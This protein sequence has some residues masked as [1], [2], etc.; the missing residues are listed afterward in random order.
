MRIKVEPGPADLDWQPLAQGQGVEDFGIFDRRFIWYRACLDESTFG[1]NLL[2]SASLPDQDSFIA[3]LDGKRANVSRHD[4]RLVAGSISP[5]PS[6]DGILTLLYEDGGRP[7]GGDDLDAR[8]GLHDPMISDFRFLPITFDYWGIGAGNTERWININ[9]DPKQAPAHQTVT[10]QRPFDLSH[11]DLRAGATLFTVGHI[12]GQATLI[13]NGKNLGRLQRKQNLAKILRAGKNEIDITFAPGDSSAGISGG[14]ELD[15][16]RHPHPLPVQWEISGQS[17]GLSQNW[18]QSNLDESDWQSATV[19]DKLDPPDSDPIHPIWIRMH[20][21]IPPQPGPWRLHLD[22]AGNGFLYLNGQA[23]GRYWEV[24]PQKDFYLPECWLNV[25]RG[26]DNT[27]T[28]FLRPTDSPL[29]I[30][31]AS[32]SQY[33]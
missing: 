22:A 5:T 1:K 24:G 30:R 8:T 3:E 7:N 23:L 27:I 26:S 13:V 33:P 14:A 9:D 11:E 20:V 18:F 32:I 17:A 25:A 15:S 19:G 29:R 21:Q 10:I 28:L 31:Q 16:T 4:S 2:L 12:R 6:G